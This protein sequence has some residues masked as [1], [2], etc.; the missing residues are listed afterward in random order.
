[1]FNRGE[2]PFLARHY[3]FEMRPALDE[4]EREVQRKMFEEFVS[5][6]RDA[7]LWHEEQVPLVR[8]RRDEV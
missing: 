7:V 2:L 5:G 1:M 4:A 6:N 3:K 8:H